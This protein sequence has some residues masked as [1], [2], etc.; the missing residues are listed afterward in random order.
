[1][2]DAGFIVGAYAATFGA[3]AIF[4]WRVLARARSVARQVPDDAKPWT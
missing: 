4:A 2:E 3:V 1:M